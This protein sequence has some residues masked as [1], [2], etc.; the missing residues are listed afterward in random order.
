MVDTVRGA[1][2]PPRFLEIEDGARI[3]YRA[4]AAAPGKASFVWLGGFNSDMSGTKAMALDDW[5]SRTGRG[6]TRFDY[7]GHGASSGDFADGTIGRWRDDA[8]AVIDAETTGPQILVGSSMGGWIALLAALARPKRTAALLLIAPAPDFT[9]RLMWERF[10]KDVQ[11]E[12]DKKGVWVAPS[13]YGE[14]PTP[15]TRRLIMEA[16]GHLLLDAKRIPLG[17]PVRIVQGMEDPDVPWRH[18]ML[19][20]DRLEDADV[21]ITL[22]KAGDHR[23]STPADLQRLEIMAETLAAQVEA[24]SAS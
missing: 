13:E 12:I 16:H 11:E 2:A 18:A 22:V 8:L 7:F 20:V 9:Q 15:I 6:L 14:D 21:E 10:S 24:A 3:A 5:A 1:E 19:L 23:L 4:S 17:V